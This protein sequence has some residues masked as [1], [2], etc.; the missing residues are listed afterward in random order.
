[1]GRRFDVA[2]LIDL[3]L[4][5]RC[6]GCGAPL[7]TLCA[8]CVDAVTGTTFAGGPQP[9]FPAP[10]PFGIGPTWVT[11][12][13]LPPLSG[14]IRGYK[15]GARRDLRTIL[16]VLLTQALVRAAEAVSTRHT[17]I[18]VVLSM[19]SSAAS[20]RA[21]GD[22][23][24]RDL[25]R[26]AAREAGLPS[27]EVLR[28]HGRVRDTAGLDAAGRA[29]NLAGRMRVRAGDWHGATVILADDILTTGASMAEATRAL[30]ATGIEVV[31]Q[32]AIAATPRRFRPESH[33]G[34]GLG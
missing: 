7:L 13:Y 9:V 19:P 18:D 2:G 28:V 3:A 15:D 14:L 21:R 26:L 23:P 12:A 24:V 30:N 29:G 17:G 33:S 32:A 25:V 10:A 31:G 6:A 22:H 27:A 8:E 16:A 5:R 11:A 34:Q 1:M 4:P 20:I